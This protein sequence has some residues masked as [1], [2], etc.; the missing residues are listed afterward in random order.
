MTEKSSTASLFE[1]CGLSGLSPRHEDEPFQSI[2]IFVFLTKFA[3]INQYHFITLLRIIEEEH[4]NIGSCVGKDITWHGYAAI[5]YLV[6]NDMLQDLFSMPLLAVMNPVGITMAPL[7][8][9]S[10]KN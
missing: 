9:F 3:G 8:E 7:P 1:K 2:A 6:V 4:R 5:N 10:S